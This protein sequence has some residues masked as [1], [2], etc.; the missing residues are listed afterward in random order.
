MYVFLELVE[1]LIFALDGFLM[2]VGSVSNVFSQRFEAK[3]RFLLCMRY[4]G[5]I[6]KQL[7]IYI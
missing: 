4:N 2:Y 5:A 6:R 1:M 7:Y 3:P